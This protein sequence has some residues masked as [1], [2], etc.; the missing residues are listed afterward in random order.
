MPCVKHTTGLFNKMIAMICCTHCG[1]MLP[2][3]KN[4]V[5]FTGPLIWKGWGP[6]VYTVCS[7]HEFLFAKC[8]MKY[9]LQ[10][11]QIGDIMIPSG[12]SWKFCSESRETRNEKSHKFPGFLDTGIPVSKPS[13]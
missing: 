7:L 8:K 9:I 1:C 4:F 12:Y 5:L 2:V 10:Y 11:F 13:G 6:L 3:R